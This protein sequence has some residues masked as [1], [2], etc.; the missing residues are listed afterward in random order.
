[1]PQLP[2]ISI[3]IP[4]YKRTDL[5]KRLLDSIA[6]QDWK[7]FEVIVTDDSPD[8]SVYTVCR[9]YEGLFLLHYYL[10]SSPLG[11]PENWNEGIRKAKGK[12]I[13]LMHDDDWFAGSDSLGVF[14]GT[15]SADPGVSFIFSAYTNSY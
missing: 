9:Q 13:K 11:T 2:L 3:C 1:M 10:N 4:A 14:A 12:W 15:V 8:D 7:D 5:L 6:I